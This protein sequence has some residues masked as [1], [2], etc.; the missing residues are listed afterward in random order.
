MPPSAKRFGKQVH[1]IALKGTFGQIRRLNKAIGENLVEMAD[2]LGLKCPKDTGQ[3]S[4]N[5]R[6]GISDKD[7]D[8]VPLERG[9]YKKTTSENRARVDKVMQ[10][11]SKNNA[12]KLKPEDFKT[13]QPWRIQNNTPYLKYID[14]FTEAIV[15]S[16]Q[17]KLSAKLKK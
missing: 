13:A 7:V 8:F 2:A 5:F 14:D 9:D 10:R 17:K 3:C 12:K 15:K 4:A 6:V 11:F 16:Y 1:G